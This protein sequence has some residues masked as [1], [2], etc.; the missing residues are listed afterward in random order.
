MLGWRVGMRCSSRSSCG[1]RGAFFFLS[2]FLSCHLVRPVACR[3]SYLLSKLFYEEWG[4]LTP[5]VL[6]CV[7]LLP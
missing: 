6:V 1:K 5:Y 4:V 3:A 2:S 7:L